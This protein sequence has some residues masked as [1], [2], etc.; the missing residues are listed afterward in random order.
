MI[1]VIHK[2]C[3]RLIFSYPSV[4]ID[5]AFWGAVYEADFTGHVDGVFCPFRDGSVVSEVCVIRGCGCHVLDAEGADHDGDGFG[6]GERFIALEIVISAVHDAVLLDVFHVVVV[7]IGR[8]HVEE[9]GFHARTESLR[10]LGAGRF[11]QNAVDDV[12]DGFAEL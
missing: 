5:I 11:W 8:K 9:W 10:D 6:A 12:D 2:H 1:D 4:W 3:G 7:G